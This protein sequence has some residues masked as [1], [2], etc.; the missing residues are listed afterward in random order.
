MRKPLVAV[1]GCGPSGLLAAY[2]LEQYSLPYAIFSKPFKS[3]LGGAQY[4]HVAIPGLHDQNEPEVML[5]YKVDGDA[6]TYHAKVYGDQVVPFV[7]FDNVSDGKQVPAWNL[8]KMYDT[9]WDML[10]GKVNRLDI[11]PLRVEQMVA[12]FDLVISSI[13]LPAVCR[14]SVDPAVGHGFKSQTV[15]IYNSALDENLSDNTIWYE[16]TRDHS[17]YRMSK[18]FGV[19][20]TEWGANAPLPPLG[21][22]VRTVNKPI[23]TDCDCFEGS[24]FLKVGRFGTWQKGILTYHAYNAVIDKLMEMGVER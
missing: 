13:H 8:H 10:E 16:G 11:D 12:G 21:D 9:L 5:T 3:P 4:S 17:Y 1:L 7:S 24:N 2:A 14:A 22:G 20:S 18:I 23:W 15:R 19:G 6:E